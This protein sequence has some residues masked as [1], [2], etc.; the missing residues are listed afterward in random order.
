MDS[1]VRQTGLTSES[2]DGKSRFGAIKC[3]KYFDDAVNDRFTRPRVGHRTIPFAH[4]TWPII[5]RLRH[6]VDQSACA[7]GWQSTRYGAQMYQRP[8]PLTSRSH[9]Q[10]G[11]LM[12][13]PGRADA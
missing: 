6:A 7:L 5:M 13:A 3:A 2:A 4:E 1:G 11:N 10:C 8:A 9:Q 12:T